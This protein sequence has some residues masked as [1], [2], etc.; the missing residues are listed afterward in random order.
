MNLEQLNVLYK[1]SV[2]DTWCFF[3]V[4]VRMWFIRDVSFH[5]I[6][7]NEMVMVMMI[8]IIIVS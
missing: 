8:I 3:C 4:Y 6:C 1:Q 5:S 7:L 2:E